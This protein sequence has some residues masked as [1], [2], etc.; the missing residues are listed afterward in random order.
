[1]TVDASWN[2]KERAAVSDLQRKRCGFFARVLQL[3]LNGTLKKC[4]L[5]EWWVNNNRICQDKRPGRLIFSS[6]KNIPKPIKIPSVLCTPPF[7]KSSIQSHRF[8][9]LPPLE[10]SPTR[11]PS[12]LCTPPFEKSPTRTPSVLCTPPFEKSL[13]L[14]GAYFGEGVYFGKYGTS[15]VSIFLSAIMLFFTWKKNSHR[16]LVVRKFH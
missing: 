13:F 6:N 15:K 7:E 4:I 14:V 11:T 1:M 9:V 8:C 12:V 5:P 3:L 10:K 2:S 16:V